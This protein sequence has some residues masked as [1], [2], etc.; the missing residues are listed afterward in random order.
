M[1]SKKSYNLNVLY[2]VE[3]VI[4]LVLCCFFT[5]KID[6]IIFHFDEF[7]R[8]TNFKELV[9]QTLY[10]GN[11][12]LLGNGFGILFS[13]IPEVFYFVEFVLVQIFCFSAEK[14]TEIK[15]S[16]VYF[17][18]VFLL[19]PIFFV[20]QVES[21]LC[22]F[23]NYFVPILLLVFILLILKK[24]GS[25]QSKAKRLFSCV[26]IVVLGFAEQLFV[27]H[28]AVMN[29]VIAV[30]VLVLFIRKKKNVLE[31]VLLIIS[32]IAGL[33]LLLGYNYYIDFE[34]TWV[35]KNDVELGTL[36]FS[37]DSIS[38][39]VKVLVSNIGIFVYVYFASIVI[40]TIMMAVILHMD[41]K[42]KTIKFKKLNVCLMA[43]YY[44]AS[45]MVFVLCLLDKLTVMRY[46]VLIAGLFALN[47]IG[48][49]YS[50]IKAVFLKMP[51]KLR[52]ISA[53]TLFYA[54]ASAVPFLVYAILGAYRGIWLTYTLLCLFVLIV[55]DFAR[56][57]YGFKFEKQLF[58]FSVCSCVVTACYIPAYAVQ[59][60]IYNYKA[61]NYK[62]E[63]YLPAS[64][65]VLVDQ[66][67]AWRF[68]EGNIDHEF[69]PYKEFKEMQ[70]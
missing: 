11:G 38:E 25:E 29:L 64:D 68:A 18:T 36:I 10:Y 44:P 13:K 14:L 57:E 30:T 49:L 7:F 28:N 21:W 69:I 67:L 59:K 65:Q 15:N 45:L 52:I 62:T 19:Q 5:P 22:G 47:I 39:M 48:F 54:L 43:L 55:A 60:Q 4:F 31:P 26:G 1:E 66:D 41:K 3:S 16:R 56:N 24:C 53:L 50:F 46:A 63:Y 17:M 61:E 9:Q 32:N 34:Q 23:I 51:V 20:K 6:D 33:A 12:R 42:D 70:K 27:Q 8:F 35:Y 58:I 37:L 40:Y 2:I